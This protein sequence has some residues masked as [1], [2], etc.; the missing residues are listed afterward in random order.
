MANQVAAFADRN[1]AD[2]RS[3]SLLGAGVLTGVALAGA[4][5]P[6]PTDDNRWTA[7]EVA[8]LNLGQTRLVVL[9]ACDT[10][11]VRSPPATAALSLQRAF[12]VAGAKAWW[13]ASGGSTTTPQPRDE[14]VLLSSVGG[15]KVAR[16]GAARSTAGAAPASPADRRGP[17]AGAP[18]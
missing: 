7:A 10:G 14:A 12:H 16:R 9:S 5:H 11:V 4:N 2:W 8:Q 17:H 13:R 1:W 15:A 3:T 6:A 18:V